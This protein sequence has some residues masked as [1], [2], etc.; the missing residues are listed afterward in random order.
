[1]HY[2]IPI[3][4]PMAVSESLHARDGLPIFIGMYLWTHYWNKMVH[5]TK[6]EKRIFLGYDD[7]I[8]EP[9]KIIKHIVSSL[10]LT[11]EDT[12]KIDAAIS[13]IQP[14]L[15]HHEKSSKT[16]LSQHW[17][18]LQ[19]EM[20]LQKFFLHDIQFT[21]DAMYTDA[22]HITERQNQELQSLHSSVEQFHKEFAEMKKTITQLKEI[23]IQLQK[24]VHNQEKKI[25]NQ[26]RTIMI[27]EASRFWKLRNRYI[28]LKDTLLRK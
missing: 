11:M 18:L 16:A 23:K 6:D 9:K 19:D 21:V 3:R 7:L 22:Q 8:N 12:K 27:M 28:K 10:S 17:G 20:Q 25:R 2:I 24:K 14:E 1:M 4:D 13:F 5:D 26:D 15:K